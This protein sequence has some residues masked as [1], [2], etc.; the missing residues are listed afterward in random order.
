MKEESTPHPPVQLRHQEGAQQLLKAESRRKLEV[1]PALAT[2]H[3]APPLLE[4]QS[5]LIVFFIFARFTTT[6]SHWSA[7]TV[8]SVSIAMRRHCSPHP[9][10][11]VQTKTMSLSRTITLKSNAQHRPYLFAS[12][13]SLTGGPPLS[14]L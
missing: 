13:E 2:V 4:K 10:V 11:S 6:P 3:V 7:P 9:L 12:Y 14:G 8:S 5:R 1:D